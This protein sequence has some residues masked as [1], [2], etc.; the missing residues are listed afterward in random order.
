MLYQD[1]KYITLDRLL[2]DLP[3]RLTGSATR[4]ENVNHCWISHLWPYH[5]PTLLKVCLGA[6]NVRIS[7]GVCKMPQSSLHWATGFLVQTAEKWTD[8]STKAMPWG[9]TSTG[10]IWCCL[11]SG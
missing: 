6:F 10:V 8:L 1:V 11:L 4:P 7:A 5:A 3:T 2:G 9:G